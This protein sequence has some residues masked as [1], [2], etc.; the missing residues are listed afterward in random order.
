LTDS[1]GASVSFT[2]RTALD[3]NAGALTHGTG[4]L[5]DAISYRPGPSGAVQCVNAPLGLYRYVAVQV[6]HAIQYLRNR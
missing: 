5:D 4:L 1:K 2:Q 3:G 6:P